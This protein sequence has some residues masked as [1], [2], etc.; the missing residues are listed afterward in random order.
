MS[1]VTIT[2]NNANTKPD[3]IARAAA[4]VAKAQAAATKAIERAKQQQE[5][6]TK[7][8]NESEHREARIAEAKRLVREVVDA[9]LERRKCLCGCGEQVVGMFKPGHDAR[10]LSVTV[11][12]LTKDGWV[13][14]LKH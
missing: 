3:A 2:T 14:E 4:N 6:A 13:P 7:R 1:T 10:L 8:L 5:K 12:E 11:A 9:E